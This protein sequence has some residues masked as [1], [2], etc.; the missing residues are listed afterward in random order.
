VCHPRTRWPGVGEVDR[1]AY[2]ADRG[3]AA[4]AVAAVVV[5]AGWGTATAVERVAAAAV[6]VEAGWG[7]AAAVGRVAAA[8]VT[9]S[10]PGARVPELPLVS[11]EGGPW[12]SATGSL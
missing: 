1:E 3:R 11:P 8:A 10:A 2:I 12:H 4:A 7:T 5:E 6:V 9:A